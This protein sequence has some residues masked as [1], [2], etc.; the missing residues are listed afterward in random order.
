M[1]FKRNEE[2]RIGGGGRHLPRSWISVSAHAP[3]HLLIALTC[4]KYLEIC[5]RAKI[6]RN[7]A[8]QIEKV[9]NCMEC[10]GRWARRT[11]F[12]SPTGESTGNSGTGF[13]RV[14]KKN[15]MHRN[16][17]MSSKRDGESGKEDS[18]A[19]SILSRFLSELFVPLS[20]QII[21]CFILQMTM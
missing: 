3:L 14:T 18:E 19:M 16:V 15:L 2:I 1:C 11:H 10:R 4:Q 21:E 20:S 7:C 17:R 8:L 5:I 6:G 9:E 12:A 13:N